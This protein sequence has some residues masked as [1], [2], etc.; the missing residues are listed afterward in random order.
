M[1]KKDQFLNLGN[2]TEKD[3][4]VLKLDQNDIVAN[5]DV[6]GITKIEIVN[7]PKYE[8][9]DLYFKSTSTNEC[10]VSPSNFSCNEILIRKEVLN[11]VTVAFYF[12]IFTAHDYD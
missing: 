2:I 9:K 3:I 5:C 6:G 12:K 8:D 1:I 7:D 10:T 11:P 4:V